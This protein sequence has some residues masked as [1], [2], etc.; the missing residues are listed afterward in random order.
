MPGLRTAPDESG[1]KP[2]SGGAVLSPAIHRRVEGTATDFPDTLSEAGPVE[3]VSV[4]APGPLAPHHPGPLLP[5]HSPRPGEEGVLLSLLNLYC[6][7]E[8][9]GDH[10]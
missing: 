8:P 10:R 4:G 6:S 9:S 7:H 2:S 5:P 3:L 1:F